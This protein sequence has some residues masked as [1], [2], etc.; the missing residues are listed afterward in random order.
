[1]LYF[2]NSS[3]PYNLVESD[4]PCFYSTGDS[5]V[6]ANIGCRSNLQ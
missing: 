5:S 1:M 2:Y 3:T 6:S 4:A